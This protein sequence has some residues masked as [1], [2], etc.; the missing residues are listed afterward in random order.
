M[1][2]PGGS[3]VLRRPVL[4]TDGMVASSHPAVSAAGARV[5]GDGGTAV[6][7]VLA[8]AA[9]SWLTLPSQCG[10]GGDAFA[11]VRE[12]DGSVWTVNGSGFGPDG[13][14]TD[15]YA[16]QGLSAVPVEGALAVAVPGAMAA[17]DTLHARGGSRDLS[18]LWEGAARAAEHGT[19]CTAK[20]RDDIAAH[21][22]MLARDPGTAAALLPDGRV[23]AVGQRL[24]YPGL[25]Q[26]IRALAKDPAGF[27]RGSLADRAVQALRAAGAPYSGDEWAIC[28]PVE[29]EPAISREYGG[30]LVHQTP[31]P[32]PGWMLLQQAAVCD[33]WLG[34]LPWLQT[35]AVHVMA[36]AARHAFAHRVRSCGS[37]TDTWRSCL[38]D[39]AVAAVRED[40]ASGRVAVGST[41][42]ADGDTTSFVAVDAEGRAVSF[43]HSL[44]FAFGSGVTVPDTGVLLN[45]RLGRSGYL[46]PGH[47]N[48]VRPRRRPL[49]TLNAWIV[50]DDTGRLRHVGNTPGGD[51]QVQWN[52]QLLSHL[53]DHH[54][55]PQQA[56][57]AP[58]FTVFPGSDA[59]VVGNPEELRCESRLGDDVLD[60][61]RARGHDVR[62]QGPWEAGGSAQVISVDH[63]QGCLVGGADSR[64]DGI[65]LGA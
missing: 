65:A 55:D 11:V 63:E 22:D 42:V 28:G 12:P 56:V 4:A 58:R 33:G 2:S 14:D 59:D 48:E 49:H 30:H 8:M 16:S 46:T 50:T 23:P 64:Q 41:G 54:R 32:T 31:P 10:V 19:P 35:E 52:M 13:G 15:F 39:A 40:I 44:A 7:A 25:A 60:G 43:I 17:I 24:T 1:T 20:T 9:M 21:A 38:D 6:D 57:D 34:G 62:V 36:Q 37:D 27:Y 61:L 5:L 29:T 53:L 45:N 47:P 3:D 26:T 51:G 18:D